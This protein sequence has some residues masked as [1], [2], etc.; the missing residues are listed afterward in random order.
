MYLY[1]PIIYTFQSV[2]K[3][4]AG[5]GRPPSLLALANC[6][7]LRANLVININAKQV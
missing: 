7:E 6:R 5:A 3:G 1:P 4:V 2:N